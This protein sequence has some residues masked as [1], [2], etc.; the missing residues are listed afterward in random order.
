MS[1]RQQLNF[2]NKI[3]KTKIIFDNWLRRYVSISGRILLTKVEGLSRYIFP[4][5]SL[6]VQDS[7]GK[8]INRLLVH[9]C[10]TNKHHHLK[11]NVLAGKKSEGGF[12]MLDYIDMNNT[13]K[14]NWIKKC[15]INP[16]SI[17]FFIP[18][19]IFKM[20]CGLDFLLTCNF[21]PSK[22]PLNYLNS[23]SKHSWP[24]NCALCIIFLLTE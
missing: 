21:V 5:L 22:L 23:T 19:N 15:V 17:C 7:T 13:F 6:I 24:G 14:I 10:W 4:G 1:V 11:T 12:E 9:F 18:H 3:K 2:N 8:H 16:D 20:V